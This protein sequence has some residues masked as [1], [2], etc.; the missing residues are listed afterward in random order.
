MKRVVGIAVVGLLAPLLAQAQMVSVPCEEF[1]A[2]TGKKIACDKLPAVKM[3]QE[4]WAAEKAAAQERSSADATPP[5]EREEKRGKQATEHQ[6][7][8]DCKLPPWKRPQGLKC[9]K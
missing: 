3:S 6:V 7:I 2:V 4:K 8:A 9:D 5:W 1:V